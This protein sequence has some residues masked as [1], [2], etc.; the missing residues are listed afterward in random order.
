MN[1]SILSFMKPLQTI[2]LTLL[3]GFACDHSGAAPTVNMLYADSAASTG[4]QFSASYPPS[5]LMNNGF[6]SP[7]DTI[8]TTATYLSAGNNYA[9]ANSTTA[10]FNL[11]FE[12]A[13][14]ATL[15]GMHVWNYAYRPNA[16]TGTTNNGVKGYSLKFYT[17][18]GA[19]GAQ[20]GAA[21]NGI[22]TEASN[23]GLNAAQSASFPS[24]Y[25]NVRSVVMTVNSNHGATNF[26]GLNE[27]AFNG[28]GS[29]TTITSFTASATFVQRPAQ[30]TLSWEINGDITSLE[31]TP[32][33]G[34][35]TGVTSGGV[36]GIN[37][38]P[39]GDQTYTLTL[40]GSIEKT[41]NVI[42]LPA[43]EKLHVYLLIG[44]SN[45][46]GEGADGKNAILDAPHPRVLKFGSRE[47]MEETFVTG[48][49]RL[50]TLSSAAG[51]NIGMGVEFGKTLIAAETDPEVV[52]CLVNHGLGSTAIQWWMPGATDTT[53]SRNLYDEA[54]ARISDVSS[55]GV[56]KGVL[57]HQGE[58][59]SNSANEFASTPAAP[60]LYAAKL[61]TLV[62][63]LRSDLGAPG[64]PFICG[65]LVPNFVSPQLAYRA[66][67]EAALAD[68]PNQRSNTH[69]VDNNG[70]SGNASDQIHFDAPSQ[71]IL[72][73][74]YANAMLNFYSNPYRLYLGGF[75]NPTL[76]GNPQ[77]TDPL[78]DIDSDGIVN[79]LE[80]AFLLDPTQSQS[81]QP[82]AY[83]S[84]MVPGQGEFPAISYRRRFDTEAPEYL[85]TVSSDLVNWKSNLDGSA[86]TQPFGIP[87][88]NGD[89]T[90][91]VTERLLLPIGPANPRRFLRVSAFSP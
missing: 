86:V 50:T 37:V 35:V 32:G 17:G 64:L 46:Q 19:T 25:A 44:Q 59:N 56:I 57:W 65:K 10:P 42:G 21:Y 89:G 47:G 5:N 18:P 77:T 24:P 88:N 9:S 30:P 76:L 23:N 34:D 33:V 7:A 72:G 43:K 85:V 53:H 48:G 63:N 68:L 52:I 79:F 84:V 13:G 40:N 51:S 75:L 27:L 36:G 11:I 8:D 81:I 66:Q 31:I 67:V 12:F 83:G 90:S 14:P 26:T 55:Y 70:L 49:H 62:D 3:L 69:C 87:V 4:G 71:R 58:Y 15:D 73:Q 60:A 91:T 74:R 45:M 54:M 38:S 16:G 41:V 29:T 61:N 39:I 28:I 22:L 80:Y 82:L 1:H 6:T 78:G 20:I 2:L